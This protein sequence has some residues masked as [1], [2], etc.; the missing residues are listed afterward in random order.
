MRAAV[1]G[2]EPFGIYVDGSQAAIARVVTD[3][4]VFVYLCDVYVERAHRGKGLGGWLVRSLRDHYAARGLSRFL[5][6]TR[7]AHAV[8]AREGFA[9]VEPGRAGWSVT[10]GP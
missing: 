2:S 9:E 1:D 8:Y 5:L 7:D 10:C 3:G 6:V 4:A